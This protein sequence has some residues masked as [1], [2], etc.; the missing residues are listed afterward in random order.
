MLIKYLIEFFY[1]LPVLLLYRSLLAILE[2]SIR[3]LRSF[4]RLPDK[5]E[6]IWL[7]F[8]GQK[9]HEQFDFFSGLE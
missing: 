8:Q 4:G 3:C 2:A 6:I 1:L 9:P 5:N 7:Q